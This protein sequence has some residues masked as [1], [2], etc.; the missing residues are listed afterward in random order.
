MA[1]R[2]LAER[3]WAVGMRGIESVW[4]FVDTFEE[5]QG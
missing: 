4:T 5:G 2:P 1:L 3:L